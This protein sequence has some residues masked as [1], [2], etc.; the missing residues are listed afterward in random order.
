MDLAGDY[1][2]FSV[3]AEAMPSPPP[4]APPPVRSFKKMYSATGRRRLARLLNDGGPDV[5]A[6]M[7]TPPNGC[8]SVSTS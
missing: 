1:L 5:R 6:F 4:F 3:S 2:D 8:P 7:T